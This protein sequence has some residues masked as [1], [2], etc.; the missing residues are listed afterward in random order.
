MHT[1]KLQHN[2]SAETTGSVR[3]WFD[4]L[5]QTDED[6]ADDEILVV[7]GSHERKG[8]DLKKMTLDYSWSHGQ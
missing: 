3:M 7:T 2:K 5:E 8:W 4:E 6:D 1:T